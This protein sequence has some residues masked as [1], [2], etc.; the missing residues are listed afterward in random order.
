MVKLSKRLQA[1]ADYVT[2][3][4]IVADI[5]SDHALLPVYLLQNGK[6]SSAIAG[7]LNAGPFHAAKKQAASAGLSHLLDVRQGDGL[8]VLTGEGEADTVTIAGMGGNLMRDILEAGRVN[9]KLHGVRKLILQP[10]VGEEAVRR[11]LA[12]HKWYLIEEA[13]IEED[14]KIYEMLVA[15]NDLTENELNA[16]MNRL[17]PSETSISQ[18][19]DKYSFYLS[20]AYDGSFLNSKLD[21]VIAADVVYK[22]GPY[23][24][25]KPEKVFI[26]KWEGEL[27]KLNWICRQLEGSDKQDAAE[28]QAAFRN[29]IK[30][31]E[32]VLRCLSTDKR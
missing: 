29:E 26:S 9:G 5:G 22:M 7:E 11:W 28:R 13:I 21:K 4:S 17:S 14:G 16:V 2:E 20:L 3:G 12:E 27:D 19:E 31:L 10:N 24:L 30:V 18:T 25:R 32:E 23:L 8:S 6:C 1:I 15:A